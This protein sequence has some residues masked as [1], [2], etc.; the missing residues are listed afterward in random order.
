M[1]YL[2]K[3]KY[4]DFPNMLH[5]VLNLTSATNYKTINNIETTSHVGL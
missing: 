2:Y 1:K 4:I 3:K 5:L